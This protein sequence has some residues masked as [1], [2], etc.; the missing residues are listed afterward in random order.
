MNPEDMLDEGLGDGDRLSVQSAHGQ[1]EVVAEADP[2][3]RRGVVSIVH[4]FGALPGRGGS[5]E[6]SGVSTNLLTSLEG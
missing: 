6:E 5:Y 4:G 2:S 1:I 3:L